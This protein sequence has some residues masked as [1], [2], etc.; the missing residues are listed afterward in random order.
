MTK[1]SDIT[2][3]CCVESG[4]LEFQT[5]RMVESLRRYGGKFANAPVVAVISRFGP[6]LSR[7]TRQIFDRYE[8][9]YLL[10]RSDMR[11]NRYSWNNFMN[12][13]HAIL[14]VDQRSKSET[15]GWL[16]SDLLFVSEPDKL[17]LRADESFVAC[18]SDPVGG[19]TGLT[20]PLEAYWLSIC[21]AL[22]LDI[23]SLP[24]VIT[25]IEQARIRYYFNSG[26]FVYRRET[27]FAKQYLENCTKILDAHISSK[28]CQYFF[29]DQVAL[30]LT[31]FQLGLPWRSLPYS[32]NSIMSSSTHNTWYSE[33]ALRKACIIHYHDSMWPA[34][35]PVFLECLRNTHP[36]VEKWL[37]SL[38]PM[39]NQAPLQWRLMDKVLKKFRA[40]ADNTYN[41]N[42]RIV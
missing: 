18:T 32:H 4:S 16:D 25:E 11:S 22:N 1:T 12:K 8:I 39:S 9:E 19:T 5:I 17:N 42:C 24:W 38:G 30:G 29:T 35:W 34:F 40:R 33:D 36:E 10:L 26:M 41:Q 13:P 28:V 14:A 23:E 21:M 20:D 3:V 6:P 15:I 37:A 2:F 31:A 7:T 27:S